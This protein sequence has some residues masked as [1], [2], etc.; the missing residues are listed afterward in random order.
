MPQSP[1]SVRSSDVL[2]LDGDCGL[3]TNLAL[4]VR[5]RMQDA[6]VLTFVGQ[7]SEGGASVLASLPAIQQQMDTI[8]LVRA[9]RSFVR[10]AAVVRISLYMAWPWRVLAA[11]VWLLPLPLRDLGYRFVAR[12]RKRW[13]APPESCAF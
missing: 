6:A 9:G 1:E 13:W 4:F 10:S 7:S 5:P 12:N 11:G 8:V 3:C 2:V